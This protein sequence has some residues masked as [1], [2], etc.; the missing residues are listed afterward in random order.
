MAAAPARPRWGTATTHRAQVAVFQRGIER[1][2]FDN[3]RPRDVDQQCAWLHEGQAV[4][5]DQ[6]FVSGASPH[7]IRTVSH[8]SS[9]RSSS[10][11]GKTYR[12]ARDWRP[13]CGCEDAAFE[14]CGAF[15]HL[16]SDPAVADDPDRAPQDFAMRAAAEL[17]ARHPRARAEPR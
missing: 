9:M 11:K 15:R 6:P 17:R 7:E 12:P 3:C 14:A 4:G 10:A 1:I 13:G 16:T 8:N 2:F 5:V